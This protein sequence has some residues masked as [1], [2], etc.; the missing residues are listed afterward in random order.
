MIR[1]Y[2]TSLL[3]VLGLG[4]LTAQECA[5]GI[6]GRDT[7]LIILVFQLSE[8]QQE[9]LHAWIEA[10]EAENAEIQQKALELLDTHPQSTSEEL[11]VLGRKYQEYKEMMLANALRYD[12]LL[13]GTFN[14]L[15]YERYAELCHEVQRSPMLPLF[16]ENDSPDH[17]E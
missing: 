2:L 8:A 12:R 11:E 10:L 16:E 1:K 15:Q 9:Q 13:L 3:L 4:S 17:P 6:G 5:L 14:D 7:D